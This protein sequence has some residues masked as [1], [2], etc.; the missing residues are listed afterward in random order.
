MIISEERRILHV[1]LSCFVM[2]GRNKSNK[3]LKE[4]NILELYRVES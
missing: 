2:M 4:R 1:L 3:S